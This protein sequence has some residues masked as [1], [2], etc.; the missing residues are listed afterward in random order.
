MRY[1]LVFLVVFY[2]A[3]VLSYDRAE[4]RHWIDADRDCQNTRAEV[5]I[6]WSIED[7]SFKRGKNCVVES[8][9]WVDPYTGKAITQASQMDV[10]HV[11]PLK[12]AHEN[13]AG[14]WS[15]DDKKAFANDF[16]NLTP[17][18][19]S[20]N[21]SKGAKGPMQWMPSNKLY[22]CDYLMAWQRVLKRYPIQ[23]TEVTKIQKT[24]VSQCSKTPV[25]RPASGRPAN[26]TGSNSDK[27]GDNT[28]GSG[29][30]K[31]N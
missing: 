24:Y 27:S 3:T 5:L 23:S 18:S 29:P 12:F 14:G 22:T 11:I 8:G 6:A 25:R 13:G 21:R 17:V 19:R 7:V 16:V 1:L 10:D 31:T 20:A 30:L 15:R 4:W 9:F 28:A 2:S 26:N